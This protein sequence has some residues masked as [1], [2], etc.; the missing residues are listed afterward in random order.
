MIITMEK[1][2]GGLTINNNEED[3][4]KGLNDKATVEDVG[5]LDTE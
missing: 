2:K 1:A 4:W 5:D 3:E